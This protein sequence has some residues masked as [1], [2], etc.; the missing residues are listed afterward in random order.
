[1]A[2][3]E[4]QQTGFSLAE[5]FRNDFLIGTAVNK[6]TIVSQSDLLK[7]H[8]NSL[9]AENEMKFERLHPE[10]HRYTFEEADQI[11]GFA[12]ENG[13]SLRGHTLVWHNQTPGWVFE[14]GNAFSS[15]STR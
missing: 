11:A 10:E 13:M 15:R 6:R 9:T 12:R 4:Q 2:E 14:D 5:A 3:Q 7:E 8:Y 1:M